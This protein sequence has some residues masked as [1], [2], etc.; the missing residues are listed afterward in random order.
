MSPGKRIAQAGHAYCNSILLSP[1]EIVRE[2]QGEDFIGTKITLEASLK[3]ILK[4]KDQLDH[5]GITNSLI[6]DKDHIELPDFDGS[7]TVT[8]LGVGPLNPQQ[9]KILSKLKLHKGN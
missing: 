3:Q 8:A 7:P 6:I 5:L 4:T 1:Q 2:Y 9:A